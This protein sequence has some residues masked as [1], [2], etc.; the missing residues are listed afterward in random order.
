[1]NHINNKIDP[2]WITGFTDAEGCFLLIVRKSLKYKLGWQIEAN[3]TINLHARDKDL[4]HFIQA[5]FGEV[6]R[7]NKE[8]NKCCDFTI[9]SLDE[10]IT[11]VLPHF[12]K[13]P[14]NTKKYSDYLLFK[15]AVLIM[16]QG[17]HLTVEGLQSII[18]I[19]ASINRGLT[20]LLL[21]AFPNSI[22]CLKP[23]KE[24]NLFKLQSQWVAGFVSGDG[25]FKTSVR[26]SKLQKLGGRV[27]LIFVITQ[28]IRDE[29]LLKS[30]K[31]F[32]NCGQTYSYKDYI[33][34][35]CQSFKDIDKSIIP[36]F[37]KYPILGIKSKDFEDWVKIANIIK[38][39]VHLTPEGFNKI[40]KIRLSM[41]RN[42]YLHTKSFRSL[43]VKTLTSYVS[44][45]SS[46]LP[47]S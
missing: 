39:G 16:K 15:K 21:A 27:S 34:Y 2:N 7:I 3:F 10:I 22:P 33:E 31:D 17:G 42:R 14:L 41:N 13:Y 36:F 47:W 19:R 38:F 25:S 32:F 23:T 24:N 6:G 5:Y 37:H 26:E 29:L 9:G 12:D 30:F 11:R 43:T 40:C 1:M 18:N 8:R 4:L 44:N 28:H 46:I 45:G 20:P 35:R